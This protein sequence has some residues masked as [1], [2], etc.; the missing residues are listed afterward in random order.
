MQC[1]EAMQ[2]DYAVSDQLSMLTAKAADMYLKI[3]GARLKLV[4]NKLIEVRYFT[5]GC[6]GLHIFFK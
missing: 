5:I 1:N 6:N 4:L 2:Y 3:T